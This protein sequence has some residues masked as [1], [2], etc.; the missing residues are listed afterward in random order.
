MDVCKFIV[1][2]WHGGT[3]NSRRAASP[4]VWL[5]E[6]EERWA[7]ILN[8]REQYSS[9]RF[10]QVQHLTSIAQFTLKHLR[11]PLSNSVELS[12]VPVF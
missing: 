6:G 3:L 11:Y 9:G 2:L 12:C 5:E 10:I 4:L 7:Q 1:P 8:R